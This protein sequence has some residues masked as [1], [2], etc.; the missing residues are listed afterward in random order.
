MLEGKGNFLP[1]GKPV[2]THSIEHP[3]CYVRSAK[4]DETTIFDFPNKTLIVEFTEPMRVT[5]T[6]EGERKGITSVGNHYFPRPCWSI[7]Y[8]LGFEKMEEAHLQDHRE[9]T[10][11]ILPAVYRCGYGKSVGSKGAIQGHD[12][13]RAC[14]SRGRRQRYAHVGG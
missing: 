2:W 1:E 5:S 6:L 12:R 4:V 11:Q 3:L 7:E 14:N 9:N 8:R 13:L 10:K